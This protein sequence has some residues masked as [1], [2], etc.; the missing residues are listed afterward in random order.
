MGVTLRLERSVEDALMQHMQGRDAG[1]AR[2][3]STARQ[4]HRSGDVRAVRTGHV[5]WAALRVERGADAMMQ[6]M[7]GKDAGYASIALTGQNKGGLSTSNC[8][9]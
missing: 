7:Q 2:I 6:H 5:L 1:N 3:D 4:A 9:R 8:P